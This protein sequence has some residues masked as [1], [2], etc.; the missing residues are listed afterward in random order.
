MTSGSS[1]A[2]TVGIP[3][4]SREFIAVSPAHYIIPSSRSALLPY[5]LSSQQTLHNHPPY[6]CQPRIQMNSASILWVTPRPSLPIGIKKP[7]LVN[8]Q[9]LLGL[10]TC[11]LGLRIARLRVR[12]TLPLLPPREK[13][14][15]SLAKKTKSRRR[16][17][18]PRLR[19]LPPN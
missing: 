8:W 12:R 11:P 4:S 14:C 16:S 3:P 7:M 2:T 9:Y 1:V 19:M 15:Y 17:G 10:Q 6:F 18:K 5:P 13:V